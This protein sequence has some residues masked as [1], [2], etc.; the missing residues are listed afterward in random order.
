MYAPTRIQSRSAAIREQNREVGGTGQEYV[1]WVQ[2][3]LNK[4]L[5]L[6]LKVDGVMGPQTRSAIRSF[7][8][9]HR[10][11]VDGIV[12]PSTESALKAAGALPI[13]VGI[14]KAPSET[15][16]GFEFDRSTLL[17]QHMAK[18]DRVAGRIA[19][20]WKKGLPI[21]TV[22]V[23]GHTDPEGKPDYNVGLGMRRSLAV[24]KEL[25]RA[26]ER[27][28]KNLSSKVLVLSAS[29]GEKDLLDRS[30]TREGQARNRRVEIFLSTI[31]LKPLPKPKPPPTPTPTQGHV[32]VLVVR[33]DN[34]QPIQGARVELVP[35]VPLAP[36]SATTG[37]DG[38][39]DFGLRD[40]GSYRFHISR[41]CF[42][43]LLLGRDVK[44]GQSQSFTATL[45]PEPGECGAVPTGP[46]CNSDVLRKEFEDCDN[47]VRAC[48]KKC[49]TALSWQ[50]A[51]IKD[52]VGLASCFALGHPAAIT[53]CALG[54]GGPA[55]VEMIDEYFRL[56]GC[57][58]SCKVMLDVCQHG[59]RLRSRCTKPGDIK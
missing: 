5:R 25:Q 12:G 29:R 54:I 52:T 48:Y 42:V 8:Q 3:S 40:P 57:S 15:L 13:P 50:M 38:I 20:T 30:G 34:G 26:M 10:L 39:A 37:P 21:R 36:A 41:T 32:A 11:A 4:I 43:G 18:I 24:R 28:Q 51:K 14:S 17:P 59:A 35:P 31:A 56:K 27:K 1:R 7:Q 16:D 46:A 22:K 49:E 19:E 33:A 55:A 23:V 53:A 45:R 47:K 44:A 58:D 9:K 2:S 6:N